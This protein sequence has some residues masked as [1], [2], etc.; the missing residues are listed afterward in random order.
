MFERVRLSRLRRAAV[1]ALAL[2]FVVTVTDASPLTSLDNLRRDLGALQAGPEQ[3][4]PGSGTDA[5]QA[6]EFSA[7]LGDGSPTFRRQSLVTVVHAAARNLDR[8]IG[9]YH[10]AGD[11]RRAGDAEML[12]LSLY[13][14]SERI[15]RLAAPA[16]QKTVVVL[17]D[18]SLALVTELVK[19]LDLLAAEPAARS[20]P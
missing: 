16:G 12:R 4:D 6:V 11:E 14:L 8:L 15:E 2:T 1:L 17:R 20:L 19:E 7:D 5:A 18:Q 3:V 13:G 10:A 9:A